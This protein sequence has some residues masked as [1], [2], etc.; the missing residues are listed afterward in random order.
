MLLFIDSP[1]LGFSM[2][3]FTLWR[4]NFFYKKGFLLDLSIYLSIF[5]HEVILQ[6]TPLLISF[7]FYIRKYIVFP[8]F[9]MFYVLK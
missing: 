1:V 5:C 3:W 7:E 2:L 6:A 8:L 4:I 9:Y